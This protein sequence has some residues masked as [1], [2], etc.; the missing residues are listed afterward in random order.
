M[1]LIEKYHIYHWI[2]GDEYVGDTKGRC[3]KDKVFNHLSDI[4]RDKNVQYPGILIMLT[5]FVLGQKR[6]YPIKQIP[7]QGNAQRTKS[8]RLQRELQWITTLGTQFPH[9]ISHKITRKRD[10]FITFPYSQINFQNY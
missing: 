6:I 10:V 3:L 1:W 5:I 4:N 8:L 9:G 7:G 2:C